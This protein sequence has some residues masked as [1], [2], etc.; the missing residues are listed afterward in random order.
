MTV[1]RS[2]VARRNY[3]PHNPAFELELPHLENR[4]PKYVLS[5]EEAVQL[6]AALAAEAGEDK[7]EV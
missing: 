4:L 1:F 2:H 7:E 5:A 3:L 6:F